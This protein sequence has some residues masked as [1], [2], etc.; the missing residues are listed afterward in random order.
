MSNVI[1][2]F[3]V[4]VMMVSAILLVFVVAFGGA[5]LVFV[6]SDKNGREK[7]SIKKSDVRRLNFK[8]RADRTG[9]LEKN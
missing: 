7:R 9:L 6:R 4:L 1:L 2:G 8:V 3:V 5:L